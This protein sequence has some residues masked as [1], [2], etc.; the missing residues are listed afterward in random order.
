MSNPAEAVA[1][2]ALEPTSVRHYVEFH[3]EQ[4]PQLETAGIPL[5]V[6]SGIAGQTWLSVSVEGLQN[7]GGVGGFGDGSECVRACMQSG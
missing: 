7:H 6:V 2:L 1:G 4:G 5:G 3:I